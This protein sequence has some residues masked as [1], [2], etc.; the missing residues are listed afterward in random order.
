[1]NAELS[2]KVVDLGLLALKVSEEGFEIPEKIAT[3]IGELIDLA[4]GFAG[5]MTEEESDSAII[6]VLTDMISEIKRESGVMA[7]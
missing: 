1:M 4:E 3:D 6:A 5:T 7:G 2:V